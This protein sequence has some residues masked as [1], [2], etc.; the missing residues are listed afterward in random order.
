MIAMIGKDWKGWGVSETGP[1]HIREK[2]PNQ[3]SFLVKKYTWGIVGAVCDGL[4]SKTYSH[5]GSRSLVN[6]VAKTAQLFDFE[7]D[8]QLFEPLLKSLW[9]IDIFPYS[10]DE[11]STTLLFTITKNNQV[12]IGRV[13]D[14]AIAVFGKNS[15]LLEEEKDMFTN[16]TVPFGRDKKIQWHIFDANDIDSV[17]MCSDGISEDIQKNKLLDFF[18]NYIATYN[19]MQSNKRVYEIKKWLKNWPVKGHSDDKT[20]VALIKALNGQDH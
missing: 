15:L 11:V 4:G 12:Y 17:V 7:K 13:G 19:G 5:I 16:Y 2:I 14:G 8:I 18:Q 6:A 3:D 20:I 10:Q 9:D 1:L